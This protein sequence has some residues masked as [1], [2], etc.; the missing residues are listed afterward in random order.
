MHV[1]ITILHKIILM[2]F[3]KKRSELHQAFLF[4]LFSL[5]CTYKVISVTHTRACN[6][7]LSDNNFAKF[8]Q[9]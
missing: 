2:R 4:F 1:F 6:I 8:A 9:S 3:Y 5:T 7:N